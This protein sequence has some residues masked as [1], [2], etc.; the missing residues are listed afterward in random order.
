MD[1]KLKLERAVDDLKKA[2]LKLIVAINETVASW[3][4]VA[5]CWIDQVNEPTGLLAR[6]RIKPGAKGEH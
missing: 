5:Q 4:Y 2:K 6:H 3:P 1:N